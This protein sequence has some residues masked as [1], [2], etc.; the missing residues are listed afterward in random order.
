MTVDLNRQDFFDKIQTLLQNIKERYELDS[1]HD[2]L[3]VWFAENCLLLDPEDVKER[4]VQDSMAEGIDAVLVDNNNRELL[5]VQAKT[6]EKFDN[7]QNSFPENDVKGVLSGARLLIRGD[8]RGKITPE[9]ENLT[10]EYHA[11]EKSGDYKTKILFIVLKQKPTSDKFIE[12]FRK[13]IAAEVEFWDLDGL[14]TFYRDVYLVRR[15]SP[16]E[17]L[18]FEVEAEILRKDTPVRSRI[19]STKGKELARNY[20]TFRDRL[21]QQN[22]RFFLGSRSKSI[23]DQ[24]LKT[25]SDSEASEN[26]WYYNNGI[27]VIC[28]KIPD[29]ATGRTIHLDGAQIINGAQTTY[30][31]YEAFKDGTLQSDVEVLVKAIETTD[32]ELIEK[33]TLYTNSQNAIKLRDLSSNE[34]IQTTTQRTLM[35]NYGYFYERKRGEFES[36][37]PTE[38]AKLKLLGQEYNKKL[39]S[40]ENAAQALLSLF[41]QKPSQAKAEKRRIFM[42]DGGFYDD[43]FNPTDNWLPEKLLIAWRLLKFVEEKKRAYRRS[44]KAAAAQLEEQKRETYKSDFLLYSEYF[45][46]NLYKDFLQDS[47][48]NIFDKP[49]VKEL[50][51]KLDGNDA[52]LTRIY[53]QIVRSFIDFFE[54]EKGKDGYYHNKFFKSEKSIA[55]LRVAVNK[56]FSFVQVLE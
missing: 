47:G 38:E 9:L 8:Y 16:P 18:S 42:K 17:R 53:D 31:L 43:I 6:V 30:S 37:Y 50:L 4:I 55:L 14:L 41:L 48:I 51:S 36:L 34:D 49:G 19:F 20:D 2:A 28:K 56:E 12:D 26:F 54:G 23:N 40:N 15:G 22:V 52:L 1:I 29:S 33:I 21:F 46:L 3:I 7:T 13:D 35:E 39:V 25:A 32:K 27:T 11:L 24:I 10:D 5:F 45:V 44:Y